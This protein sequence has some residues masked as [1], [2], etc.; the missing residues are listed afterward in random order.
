MCGETEVDE[1]DPEGRPPCEV[2]DRPQRIAHPGPEAEADRA[3]V[4][5]RGCHGEHPITEEP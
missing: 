5:R 1:D 4:V 2:E 3:R